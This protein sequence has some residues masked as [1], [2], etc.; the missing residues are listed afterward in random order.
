MRHDASFQEELTSCV[1]DAVLFDEPLDRHTSMG[2][3]G[4]ADALVS[5]QSPEELARLISLLRK[6]RAPYLALGNGTNLLVRDGGFRG[7]V[8]SLQGLKQLSWLPSSDGAIRVRAEAGVPLAAIVRLCQKESLTGMEFCAGIP[9]SVGGAVRMN[10]GAYGREMKDVV[11]EATVLNE[12]QALEHLSRRDLSFEYR[13]LALPDSAVIVSAEFVLYP[14]NREEI[15]AK[16]DEI[17]SLRKKKHPLNLRNAGSIFKN[18]RS[19]PAGRLIEE[20]GLKGKRRGD[21]MVSELHGNFIVNMGHAR[22]AEIVDLM[23]EIQAL[24]R[25]ARDI[26]LEAEVRIVGEDG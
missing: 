6:N 18:P 3:G 7:V 24:V 8:V 14:G 23:E 16:I 5:P 21:A 10:A 19:I 26:H 22:T 20:V 1:S 4:P 15:S 13:R 2:V 17:L 11:A 12:H 25:D 9:G